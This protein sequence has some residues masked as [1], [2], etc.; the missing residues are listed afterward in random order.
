MAPDSDPF[1]LSLYEGDAQE[2]FTQLEIG[3]FTAFIASLHGT[4]KR[5]LKKKE[6]EREFGKCLAKHDPDVVQQRFDELGGTALPVETIR[7][8]NWQLTVELL[9]LPPDQQAPR[10]ARVADWPQAKPYDH[11]VPQIREKIRKKLKKYRQV[12]DRLVLVINVHNLGGFNVE[13]DG[14]DALFEKGGIWNGQRSSPAAIV[15]VADTDSYTVPYAPAF[16]FVNPSVDPA[17][18]PP[19]LFRL[20]YRKSPRRHETFDGE[21]VASILGLS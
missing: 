8:D 1:A 16:L 7:F 19:A 5:L 13:V 3:N 2:K 18:L 12:A 9:P 4:L 6:I 10:K 20:R 14:H 21:S 11:S 15:F 17:A